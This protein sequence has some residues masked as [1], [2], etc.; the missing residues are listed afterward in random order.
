MGPVD[1]RSSRAEIRWIGWQLRRRGAGA[2][3]HQDARVD[4]LQSR[5]A[6]RCGWVELGALRWPQLRAASRRPRL[7]ASQ[8]VSRW[9]GG[10]GGKWPAG[11]K[12]RRATMVAYLRR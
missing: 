6:D 1:S 2:S 11:E 9:T 4:Q 8:L 5:Q 12:R 3:A 7:Y 10:L